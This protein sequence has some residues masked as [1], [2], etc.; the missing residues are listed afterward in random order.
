MTSHGAIAQYGIL[1]LLH[2]TY[3]HLT[4]SRNFI[5][6]LLMSRVIVLAVVYR[7]S[8]RS[9]WRSSVFPPQRYSQEVQNPWFDRWRFLCLILLWL[10]C[11]D[12]RGE[13]GRVQTERGGSNEPGLPNAG[14]YATP[15]ASARKA[16]L[17]LLVNVSHLVKVPVL[18][19]E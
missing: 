16:L 2:L 15:A 19:G 11:P 6:T 9:C 12:P 3:S 5:S 10:P 1:S 13:R 17:V 8:L 18:F 14:E 4:G 7:S